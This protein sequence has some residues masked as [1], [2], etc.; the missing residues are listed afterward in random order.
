M[1]KNM[2]NMPVFSTK[3]IITNNLRY[4]SGRRLV[5]NSYLS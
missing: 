1:H 5:L 3:E 2:A 4:V